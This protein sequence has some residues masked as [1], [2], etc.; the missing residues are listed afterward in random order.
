MVGLPSQPVPS[1]G[2]SYCCCCPAPNRCLKDCAAPLQ[3]P[4]DALRCHAV[5]CWRL[6]GEPAG[7]QRRFETRE[8]GPDRDNRTNVVCGRARPSSTCSL[9]LALVLASKDSSLTRTLHTGR[10]VLLYELSTMRPLA[11]AVMWLPCLQ[12]DITAQRQ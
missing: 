7:D 12:P 1:R 10:T 5:R 6:Y 3:V 11:V 9:T 8:G 4:V 2:G